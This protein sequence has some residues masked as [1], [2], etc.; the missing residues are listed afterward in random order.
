MLPTKLKEREV[1]MTEKSR[2]FVL[3]GQTIMTPKERGSM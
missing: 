3:E 1:Y 2:K